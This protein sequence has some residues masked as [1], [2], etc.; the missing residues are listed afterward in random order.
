MESKSIAIMD[1]EPAPSTRSR[2]AIPL[3]AGAVAAIVVVALLYLRSVA[4]P[5]AP[6]T[7][8]EIPTLSGP[9][10][11]TYD[12]ISPSVGW[13]LVLDYRPFAANFWIFKTSDGAGHWTLLYQG[14]SEGGYTYLHF[15]DELHGFAYAGTRLYRTV[16]GGRRWDF[17]TVLATAG[18]PLVSFAS[19]ELGWALEFDDAGDARVY[20]TTD[21]GNRWMRLPTDLPP[22]AAFGPLGAPESAGFTSSGEGWLGAGYFDSPLVYRSTDGGASWAAVTVPSPHTGG[23]YMTAVKLVPGGR[24]LVFVSDRTQLVSAF[25]SADRGVSWQELDPPPTLRSI[26]D[27]SIADARHWW[28]THGGFLY[29]TSDAGA[30][31]KQV[32][33]QGVPRDWNSETARTIDA[34]HAW[35]EMSSPSSSNVSALAVTSDGGAHW[36]MVSPP[37]PE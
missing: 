11:V 23:R 6:V 17:V 34:S 4:P 16:D 30:S 25:T 35:W 13:A 8:A 3:I 18:G 37:Q 14:Q 29:V 9:Y 15:F 22:R 31:W 21:G 19:P 5:A 24:V 28:A 1:D 36:K 33:P 10:T 32:N 12:F 7:P 20:S 2:R 26:E 27:L